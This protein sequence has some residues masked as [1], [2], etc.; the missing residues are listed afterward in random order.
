MNRFL[1]LLSSADADASVKEILLD[2]LKRLWEVV[3]NPGSQQYQNFTVSGNVMTNVRNIACGV[4]LGVLI[5]MIASAFNRRVLGAF[6]RALIATESFSSDRA[7]TLSELGFLKNWAVKYSLSRGVNLRN[8][9]RCVEED[10]WDASNDRRYE[11]WEAAMKE[12]E[13]KG[14]AKPAPF[15]ERAYTIRP[16]ED[17]FYIP[18]EKKYAA[19]IKYEK[20]GTDGLAFFVS[21][22]V[23][24][25]AFVIFLVL[26]PDVLR[27]V[28]NAISLF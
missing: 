4:I 2:E 1:H 23:L 22:V 21:I 3:L 10:E 26:L 20:K 25:A 24:V 13:E 28:D 17:H 11:A 7:K 16:A 19:E 6:V 9:V 5:A 18:E 8:S 12:A 14:T 27:L 15:K